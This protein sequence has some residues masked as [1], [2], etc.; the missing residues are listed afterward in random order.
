MVFV[1]KN[2]KKLIEYL[3]SHEPH[4]KFGEKYPDSFYPV[5]SLVSSWCANAE[6]W[7]SSYLKPH[8][9]ILQ[10]AGYI[11]S[12]TF[13]GSSSVHIERTTALLYHKEHRKFLFV[14]NYLTPICVTLM[15]QLVLYLSKLFLAYI[16]TVFL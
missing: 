11:D 16:S 4:E 13:Y 1:D 14:R 15:T 7:K 5:S 12:F 3:A 9:I 10:K 6:L 8:L 2:S